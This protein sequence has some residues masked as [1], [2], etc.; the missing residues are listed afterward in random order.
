MKIVVA[1]GYRETCECLPA[2]RVLR[3]HLAGLA[4]EE[5]VARIERQ[6]RGGYRLASLEDDG[7]VR[8]V[9]GFRILEFLAW[10][11]VLYVD[12][13]ITVPGQ[14]GKGYGGKLLDWLIAHAGSAGCDEIHLDSGYG[15][16][17][18]HRLYLGRRLRLDCHHF[19]MKL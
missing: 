13:L 15:R 18:A 9:A 12:D 6:R 7:E 10:G 1:E 19:S 4:D 3:P 16:Y 8:S 2:L 14:V 5:L 11:K 17:E